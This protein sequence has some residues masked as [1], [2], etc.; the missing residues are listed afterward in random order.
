MEFANKVN[1]VRRLE[2]SNSRQYTAGNM[3]MES[4]A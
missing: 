2:Q 1:G 3:R 4:E